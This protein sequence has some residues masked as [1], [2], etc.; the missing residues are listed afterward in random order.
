MEAIGLLGTCS[1]QG[2]A[3][4]PL[5]YRPRRCWAR[6]LHVLKVYDVA[7]SGHRSLA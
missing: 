6:L 7:R 3:A 4:A 2:K 1:A 5:E